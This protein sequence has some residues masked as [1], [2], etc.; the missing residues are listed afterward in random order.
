[1]KP[2]R[3]K[4]VPWASREGIYAIAKNNKMIVIPPSD[5][6]PPSPSQFLWLAF[7]EFLSVVSNGIERFASL[8][9]AKSHLLDVLD[10]CMLRSGTPLAL[11]RVDNE[12]KS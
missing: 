1:M 11:Y 9:S 8:N 12:S 4:C 3:E 5:T 10:L 6:T 2:Y 7:P